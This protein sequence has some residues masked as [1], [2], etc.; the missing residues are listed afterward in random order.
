MA[1]VVILN[2]GCEKKGRG[3]A[4]CEPASR[5]VEQMLKPK[6][7]KA[8]VFVSLYPEKIRRILLNFYLPLMPRLFGLR[9]NRK[10]TCHPGA[11]IT[12]RHRPF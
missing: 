4:E 3:E 5:V 10:V 7:I 2:S 11:K 1:V 12:R 9:Q 8:T 6:N